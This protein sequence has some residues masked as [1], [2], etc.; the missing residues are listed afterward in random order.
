MAR[1]EGSLDPAGRRAYIEFDNLEFKSADGAASYL[2]IGWL[3]G[4]IR[5]VRPALQNG[6]DAQSWLDTTYLSARVRLG[7]GNKGSIFVLER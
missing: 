5:R 6:A 4:L 2:T 3:F 7:R 1:V